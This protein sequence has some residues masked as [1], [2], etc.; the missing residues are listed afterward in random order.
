MIFYTILSIVKV[1][2]GVLIKKSNRRV[3][4]EYRKIYH[5]LKFD[6]QLE[7]ART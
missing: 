6:D 7:E 3:I 2:L 5:N 1:N 4:N